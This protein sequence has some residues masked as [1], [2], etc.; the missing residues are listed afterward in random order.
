MPQQIYPW[1]H[2]RRF[3]AYAQ[4]FKKCFGERVQKL[5]IDAG[6]SC[7]NRD[8]KV[9]RGG[10]TY[11][12]NDSFNPSYCTTDK[13]VK[14]QIMEGIEFHSNRYRRADKYL[15][16]FQ[17]YSN[18]YKP[19]SELK[20]IYNQALSVPGVVGLVIGTR[21][22]V[23]DQEKL[24]Y[25]AKLSQTK[26]I[27]VEY[28]IE[29]CYNNTLKYINRG[30]DFENVVK[31]I[32]LTHDYG[33]KV[34]GHMIFGLPNETRSMMMDEAEILNNLPLDTIKFHQLQIITNTAM[35][36]DY[37]LNSEKYKLFEL[38]EYIEF[39]VD[40]V[41]RLNPNF[42][43]ERFAGE[44]PPRFL[45]GP[46]WGRIRNDQILN[47]IEQKFKDRDTWQGKLIK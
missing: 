23:I 15:A 5:S 18:T 24:E 38:D 45:A 36:V 33:I 28:G 31:A 22:D 34:G 43:I 44:V 1:G 2:N 10:C 8:G 26:Y 13:S 19:L 32:N 11:C 41:E 46:S 40:F 6:F 42:V 4:Y 29:S 14:Q 47:R 20:E 7:P 12:N 3:N 9:A 17:A 35:A 25:L 37:K 39:I 27:I 21:S 16:Y 30:H